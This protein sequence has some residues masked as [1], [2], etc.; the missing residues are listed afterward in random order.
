LI[1]AQ[2]EFVI[3]PYDIDW[4]GIVSNIVYVRWL[5]DLRMELLRTNFPTYEVLAESLMPVLIRTEIDYRS[6][7]R[8][9]D[10]CTGHIVVEGIG[11][12]SMKLRA[13]FRKRDGE[14]AAEARQT[15]VF[16]N[17]RT[18]R[19]VSLPAELREKFAAE[20]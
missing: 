8:F 7:L 1:E 3:R 12:V 20:K 19:P 10:V 14:I 15:G 6:A 2:M 5:E 18:G 17:S 4:G 13:A 16:V 11:R 9:H